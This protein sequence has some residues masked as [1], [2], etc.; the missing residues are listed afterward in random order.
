MYQGFA[1]NLHTSII[2]S[3]FKFFNDLWPKNA[4]KNFLIM[5][6]KKKRHFSRLICH[7]LFFL[8]LT[9]GGKLPNTLSFTAKSGF[10]QGRVP[11]QNSKR[12]TVETLG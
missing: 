12:E 2:Q 11:G 9:R 1:M 6:A 10:M 3:A 4:T 8:K 7:P 5:T